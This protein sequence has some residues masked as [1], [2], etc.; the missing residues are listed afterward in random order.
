MTTDSYF[1]KEEDTCALWIKETHPSG[2][3]RFRRWL[4]P[5]LTVVVLLVLIIALAA[6][7]TKTSNRLWTAEQH[8][9]NL[10]DIILSLNASLQ[11]AHET[12]REVQRLQ[13]AVENN[14]DQL[15]S[16]SEAL[17][18]LSAVDSL[19]R[20]VASLKC[21]LE[22][23]INNSS[24]TDNCCPLGWTLFGQNCY[25]FSR[26]SLTWNE[27]RAWC[28]RQG[29][30][31][32]IL[33]TDWEFVTRHTVPELFWV[34]LSDWRTGKWEWVNQTPYTM[35]RRHW[36]PGQPDNWT[37][38]GLGAG[39][40][41]CAHLHSDGRLNDLHCSSRLRYVCQKHSQHT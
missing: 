12:V 9:S 4:L 17:K 3:L 22:H 33:H 15:S 36:V 34:G 24:A 20:S 25:F 11:R 21:S 32:V 1:E 28:D 7:N 2:V 16:V 37:G 5:A 40:E 31:L 8:V 13:S 41:D 26:S 19:S 10:S 39:D 29:A 35:E 30:H 27:S 18:Q 6:S 38:H 23:I 14:K